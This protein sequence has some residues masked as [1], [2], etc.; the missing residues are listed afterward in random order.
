MTIPASIH[1]ARISN[2]IA[3]TRS[4]GNRRP[5][6]SFS[7]G[8]VDEINEERCFP[9]E[10]VFHMSGS[11]AGGR[12]RPVTPVAV[13]ADLGL[14]LGQII[15]GT[16]YRVLT[17]LGTGGMGTVYAAEHVQLEK[18]VAI[19]VLRAD[20]AHTAGA[21]DRL[22]DEA[23]AAS[24]IGSQF[25]CDVTDF[26]QIPD[27]RVF[28]VMEYLEGQSLGKALKSEGAMAPERAL[29]ILRQICKALEAAHEKGIVHLDM[30]PDNVMLLGR[31]RR[32]DAVKVVDF[33]VA[34]LMTSVARREDKV[35][36]TPEYIS[37]ERFLGAAYDHRADIYALGVLGYEALTGMVPFRGTSYLATLTMHVQDPPPSLDRSEVSRTV[38][39]QLAQVILQ[40]LEKDPGARPASMAVVEAMLCEAQIASRLRT[41][42]DDLELPAVDEIWRRKLAERMPSPWGK[43]K[44]ALLGGALGLAALGISAAVYY[45]FVRGPEQVVRYVEVTKTQ[46]A[47]PVAAWLE[48]A[49]AAA[50]EQKFTKPADDSALAYIQRAESEHSRIHD[51]D[52]SKSR[53]AED[54]RR[55]YAHALS[56]VGEELVRANLRHLA[57]LKFK[58]ALRFTPDDADLAAKSELSFDERAR[59]RERSSVTR[60]RAAPARAANQAEEAREAAREAAATAYLLAARQ[61]RY[62]EARVA[63]RTLA[64]LDKTGVEEAKLADAFRVRA[65]ELWNRGDQRGAQPLYQLTR[66]LDPLDIEARRRAAWEPPPA[67]KTASE[68]APAAAV[69]AATPAGAT[70]KQA[71]AAARQRRAQAEEWRAAP[72]DSRA[73]R[74]ATEEGRAALSRLSL[75]VAEAAFNRAL[76][77]DPANVAAIGGLAEVAFER[78]RYTEALDYAR[79]AAQQ[80][81]RAP[82]YLMLLGDAYFKLL[83]FADA[84]KA[85]EKALKIAPNNEVV[86]SRMER[87]RAKMRE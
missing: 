11:S 44:K 35:S 38:P 72:R 16:Q 70:E 55:M 48:K 24:K 17:K 65:D 66:D 10:G 14:P 40:M 62:S 4:A 82:K 22:R 78:S 15:P 26:G 57:A 60:E 1:E 7:R 30:K 37:P 80:A 29:P 34:R 42:W 54:L 53:G 64:A 69:A 73:S 81:P 43:Q 79:R 77:A 85:Y 84:Q 23:R 13:A 25:I 87:V 20:V 18:R 83:R 32:Q 28:F 3:S 46:E 47:E 49:V 74:V 50:R 6:L 56:V 52:G 86:R 61:G 31:G 68:P 19:K 58:D 9:R 21:I 63:L 67:P 36:G 39:G 71:E 33:G 8:P 12:P 51:H 75:S 5:G 41:A 59:L 76:E 45:G 2:S 27:G